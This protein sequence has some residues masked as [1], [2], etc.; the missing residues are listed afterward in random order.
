MSPLKCRPVV[1]STVS[2][3][4]ITFLLSAC[5]GSPVAITDIPAMPDAVSLKP[6]EDRIADTLQNNMQQDAGMRQAMGVG[7]KIEQM[8]YRLPA[9]TSWDAVKGFY[10]DKLKGLGWTAGAGGGGIGSAVVGNMVSDVMNQVNK[11]NQ[12]VQTSLYSRGN[13]T[14]TIIRQASPTDS[15]DL[16][17]LMSLNTN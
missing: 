10:D 14:L 16:Y 11:S 17:L 2:L 6:G 7:G 4:C 8:A 5:G 12:L 3:L 13:Q 1:F 9:A 15:K